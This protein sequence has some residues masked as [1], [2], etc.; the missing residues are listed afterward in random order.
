MI[1]SLHIFFV[2]FKGPGIHDTYEMK[3]LEAVKIPRLIGSSVN[4]GNTIPRKIVLPFPLFL[5]HLYVPLSS[6]GCECHRLD[7]EF[8][9]AG[10]YY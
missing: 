9:E 2:Y 6:L 7:E 8:S 5:V 10:F 1:Q 4:Q 3:F